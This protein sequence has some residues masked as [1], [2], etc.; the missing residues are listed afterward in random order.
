MG[1]DFLIKTFI[2]QFFNKTEL[3]DNLVSSLKYFM[4]E[5]KKNPLYLHVY[6]NTLFL[7]TVH[8]H[9]NINSLSMMIRSHLQ[10]DYFMI[11]EIDEYDGLLPSAVWEKK[12]DA[13]KY[14]KDKS[15]VL[16][17]YKRGYVLD[18]VKKRSFLSDTENHEPTAESFYEKKIKEEEEDELELE[19][20]VKELE[21]GNKAKEKPKK[22]APSKD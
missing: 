16:N 9:W 20:I 15:S 12:K 3:S 8:E 19:D 10:G 6:E 7:Y 22:K 13:N 11:Y 17:K 14:Y 2:V 4:F 5:D 1:E 21:E 18:K